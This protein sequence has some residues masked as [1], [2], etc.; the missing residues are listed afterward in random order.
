MTDVIKVAK[1]TLQEVLPN[2]QTAHRTEVQFNPDTLKVSYS[3]QIAQAKEGNAPNEGNA[4]ALQHVG[5]GSTKL[6][7]QLWFDVTGV[8]PTGKETA[9][10]RQLTREVQY[11]ITPKK[12]TTQQGETY[13]PP[14]ARFLWGSFQF[15]GVMESL[16]ESLEFFGADGK[17]LR[18]SLTIG[19]TKQEITLIPE[20]KTPAARRSA[21]AKPLT[22]VVLGATLQGMADAAGKG[23][24]WKAIAQSNGIENPR[25]LQPGQLIDLNVKGV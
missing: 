12:T 21:G 15:E 9:D 17:P 18:A 25:L 10:V 24:N 1:A 8:L 14:M 13:I 2:G 19:L 11:F 23:A 7:V 16:E 20:D 6:S 22:P 3:N 5:K 4:S